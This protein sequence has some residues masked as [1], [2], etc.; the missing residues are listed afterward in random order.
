MTNNNFDGE[1]A[2]LERQS[3]G[4][5]IEKC[6]LERVSCLY[7]RLRDVEFLRREEESS[8]KKSLIRIRRSSPKNIKW[9][10]EE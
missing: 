4:V 5:L 6:D 10:E 1:R 9:E 8:S 2:W 3:A 7:G